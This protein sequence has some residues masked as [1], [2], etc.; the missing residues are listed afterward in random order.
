MSE[1]DK[2]KSV[3]QLL[4]HQAHSSLSPDELLRFVKERLREAGDLPNATVEAQI[5]LAEELAEFSLG[6]FLLEN[7]GLNAYWT[8]QLVTWDSNP[9]K[10]R[11]LG[12]LER[13][14]FARLPAVLA[15]RERFGIFRQQLQALLRPG[16]M[17]ASV[18]CGLM[19]DLLL[20]DYSRQPNVWLFGVDLDM[21]ALAGALELAKDRGIA[22]RI[23]L[24]YENAWSIASLPKV[25]VI[26]SNGLNVYEPNDDRVVELYTSFHNH[27]LPGGVLITSFMTPPPILSEKSAWVEAEIDQSLLPLQHLLFSRII[28]A[29]WTCF[30]TH[31]Q[32][33]AQLEKAGF[34]GIGFIND[35]ARMF[36]TVIAHKPL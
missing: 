21:Q 28:D 10:L 23:S 27:L 11:R 22:D 13:L 14:I 36:P 1:S 33:R 19:G 31:E 7:R 29:K 15:T 32:T 4:S 17:M 34:T 35:R 26:T 9:E 12:K 30:R 5:L 20:L 24:S 2:P 16:I 6:R 8:H 25:D 18:P 3:A